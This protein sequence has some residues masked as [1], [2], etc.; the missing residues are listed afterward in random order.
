MKL[1]QIRAGDTIYKIINNQIHEAKVIKVL[2]V[3]DGFSFDESSVG[4]N[5]FLKKSDAELFI[6]KGE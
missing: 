3:T 5:I 4:K 2:Y 6:S 1:E